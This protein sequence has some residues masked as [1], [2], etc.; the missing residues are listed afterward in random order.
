[1]NLWLVIKKTNIR[2]SSHNTTWNK[3]NMNLFT[4]HYLRNFSID[5]SYALNVSWHLYNYFV[6]MSTNI[7]LCHTLTNIQHILS[8]QHLFEI[9]SKTGNFFFMFVMLCVLEIP[10]K[11]TYNKIKTL[12]KHG[13]YEY[14]DY[15]GNYE[16]CL[17]Y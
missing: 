12:I 10:I 13:N 3:N 8:I 7:C 5:S 16:Y 14:I 4:H 1:M 11:H 17:I 2:L 15:Q 6:I 9:T